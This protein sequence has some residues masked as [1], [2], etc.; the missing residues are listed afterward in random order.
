MRYIYN[1]SIYLYYAFIYIASFFNTKAKYWI[2]GRKESKNKWNEIKLTKEPIAWFHAA[3]LGEFEQGRPVIELFKKEFPNYKILMTFFSPS[4]FNVRKNYSIADWVIYLPIDTPKQSENFIELVNPKIVFFIK[5]EFWFNYLRKLHQKNI[6]FYLIS[7]I[8]RPNQLFFK[9]YGKWFRKHLDYFSHI[10]VQNKISY[11][12]LNLYGFNNI[13]ICGDTRFDRVIQIANEKISIPVIENFIGNNK[14]FIAGSTWEEDEK[15]IISL[16]KEPQFKLKYIIA[17]HE[18]NENNIKR[19]KSSIPLNTIEFSKV[20]ETDANKYDCLII[21]SIGLLSKIYY[22]SNICYVG[23]GF[24][25]GIHNVLE[26]AVFGKPVIFG[27]NYKKFTEAKELIEIGGAFTINNFVDLIQKVNKLINEDNF[28]NNCCNNSY[29]YVKS[30]KGGT[31][32]I[33]S[34]LK[35]NCLLNS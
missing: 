16:M 29:N 8:F 23:G 17:P 7:G 21:D 19:L 11:E 15:I 1:I 31:E 33:I 3:S 5:Y 30:K 9:P 2:K 34:F 10:F 35:N 20:S 18:V 22:Y 32:K 4:G 25:K 12:L 28:Y 24:G 6:Q 26:A 27:K 13:S 14:V